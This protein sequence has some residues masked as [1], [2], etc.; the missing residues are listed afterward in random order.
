[1]TNVVT[2]RSRRALE[3]G[4]GGG[5]DGG[6]DDLVTRV[7]RLEKDVA[8][9]KAALLR[10]EPAVN[11]LKGR[12]QAM[13]TT[14]QLLTMMLAVMGVVLALSGY[15]ITRVDRVDGRIDRLEAKVDRILERLP[16]QP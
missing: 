2:L 7:D 13:P 10:I 11:E 9:V 15:T 5:H 1:M 8:D 4:G 14:W 12:S 6:M 3:T 16:H